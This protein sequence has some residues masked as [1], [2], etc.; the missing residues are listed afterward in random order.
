MYIFKYVY[1][2]KPL[3]ICAPLTLKM[4][5]ILSLFTLPC[6]SPSLNSTN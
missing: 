1:S 6:T 2:P 3:K 5:S 4:K